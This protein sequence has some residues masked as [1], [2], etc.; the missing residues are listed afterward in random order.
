[1]PLSNVTHG[2]VMNLIAD[3]EKP[4]VTD[5]SVIRLAPVILLFFIIAISP[6]GTAFYWAFTH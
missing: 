3:P 4:V 1:M 6:L 5:R 2:D